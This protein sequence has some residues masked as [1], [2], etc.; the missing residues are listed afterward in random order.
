MNR[1]TIRR[2]GRNGNVRYLCEK[3]HQMAT[4]SNPYHPKLCR[5]RNW[6]AANMVC[7][8]MQS[9]ERLAGGSGNWQVYPPEEEQV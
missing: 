2:I 3:S 1:Y 9:D 8:R 7:Q 6:Q 5:W 4:T